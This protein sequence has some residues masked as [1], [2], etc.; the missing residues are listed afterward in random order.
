MKVL[1]FEILGNEPLLLPSCID[2][3]RIGLLALITGPRSIA[4]DLFQSLVYALTTFNFPYEIGQL[5]FLLRHLS[6]LRD[7]LVTCTVPQKAIPSLTPAISQVPHVKVNHSNTKSEEHTKDALAL[8]PPRLL[9][10]LK[11]RRS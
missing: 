9:H 1:G 10:W 6:H 11:L 2:T 8:S 4:F 7:P 3:L 5:T